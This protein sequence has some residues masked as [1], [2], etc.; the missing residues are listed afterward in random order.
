MIWL[1]RRSHYDYQMVYFEGG[2]RERR[3]SRCDTTGVGVDA[4]ESVLVAAVCNEFTFTATIGMDVLQ[5]L[6]ENEL[7]WFDLCPQ[8]VV[9]AFEPDNPE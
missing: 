7:V 5:R 9:V 4:G 8:Q 2:W 3:K 6:D 1:R